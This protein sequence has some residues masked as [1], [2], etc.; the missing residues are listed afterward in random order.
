MASGFLR[1]SAGFESS[2]SGL[3]VTCPLMRDKINS[4][5]SV[6]RIVVE[7]YNSSNVDSTIT[8]L[9][10]TQTEDHALGSLTEWV[11]DYQV[12]QTSTIGR[13]QLAFDDFATYNG[14][15]AAYAVDCSL[16]PNDILR[17]VMVEE[18]E[19]TE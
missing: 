15:E 19:T 9:V 13:T 16:H 11:W 12:L 7:L 1:H 14:N 10:H 3:Q 17:H 4:A 18:N 6:A 5:A 2:I 8:C